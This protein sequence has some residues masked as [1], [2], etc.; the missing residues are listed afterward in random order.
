[1][2]GCLFTSLYIYLTFLN[3]KKMN[4]LEVKEQ[5]SYGRSMA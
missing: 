5:N 1:M 3:L 2:D 4:D